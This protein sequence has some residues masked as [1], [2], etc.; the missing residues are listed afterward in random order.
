[1]KTELAKPG[2]TDQAFI[3]KTWREQR[4]N[5]LWVTLA[6]VLIV[7]GVYSLLWHNKVFFHLDGVLAGGASQDALQES[8]GRTEGQLET[9]DQ[10]L[11]SQA[12]YNYLP[13]LFIGLGA[14]A[15][16]WGVTLLTYTLSTRR[17]L[18][19]VDRLKERK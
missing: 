8:L 5:G 17:W 13:D 1:M 6:I 15:L 7:W 3:D 16:A 12:Y 19:I 9:R 2:D 11:I 10:I 18:R 4:L 14:C